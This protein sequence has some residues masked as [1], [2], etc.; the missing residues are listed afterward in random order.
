MKKIINKLEVIDV[1]KKQQVVPFIKSNEK[2]KGSI[3]G[4]FLSIVTW[5]FFSIYVG[6]YISYFFNNSQDTYSDLENL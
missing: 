1:F 3:L 2:E 4:G 6:A 5:V